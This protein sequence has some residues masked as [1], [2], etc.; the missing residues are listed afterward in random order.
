MFTRNHRKFTEQPEKER[1]S[2]LLLTAGAVNTNK[3]IK[4]HM[5][6]IIEDYEHIPL[7]DWTDYFYTSDFDLSVTLLCKRQSLISI[8]GKANGKLTFI[9]KNTPELK[10]V[11]DGYWSG[12]VTVNPLE[13]SNAR[14]NLKTRIFGMRN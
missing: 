3:A 12:E 5:N 14:K 9:F 8:D 13:F 7:N 1:I 4:I 6:T 10:E 2:V 11:F